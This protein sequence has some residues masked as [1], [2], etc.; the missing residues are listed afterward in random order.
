MP[1]SESM[2]WRYLA[3]PFFEGGGEGFDIIRTCQRIHRLRDT[4]FLS[5]NLL[6]AQR[7][8]GRFFTRQHQRLIAAVDVQRLG[9]PQNGGKG[10]QSGADQVVFRLLRG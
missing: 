10:L 8:A 4:G 5:Q 9:T 7:Q 2:R 1:P 3:R 6:R